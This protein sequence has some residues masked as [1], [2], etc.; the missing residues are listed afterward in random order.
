MKTATIDPHVA[1]VDDD[2]DVRV[3]LQALLRSFGYRVSLYADAQAL[4][5]AGVRDVD[6]VVSDGQIPGIDG[7]GTIGAPPCIPDDRVPPTPM[8]VQTHCAAGRHAFWQ[9]RVDADELVGGIVK[10]TGQ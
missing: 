8:C 2:M 1:L 9:N 5:D 6:C 3:S 4:L 7:L 10:A